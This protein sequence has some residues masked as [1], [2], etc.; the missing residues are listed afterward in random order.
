MS[1]RALAL[2]IPFMLLASGCTY[3]DHEHHSKA[4]GPGEP[5]PAKSEIVSANIDTGAMLAEI[6]PGRGAG[7]FI[8]YAAGGTWH[9]YTACDTELSEHAC[10]WD[11]IVS[12]DS[13]SDLGEVE[14]DRLEANDYLDWD[15]AVSVRYVG[16]T[17]YDFDGF[18]LTTTPGAT[19]RVDVF[20]DEQPAQ[21]YVYWI[22]DGALHRGA[23]TNPIDLTPTAP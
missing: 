1:R 3:E 20:L 7:A 11:I 8:E 19:L 16:T 4:P 10:A 18:W 21:R 14:G 6:E 2:L 5:P 12:G 22:G 15:S 23:P 9:L 13:A 17:T